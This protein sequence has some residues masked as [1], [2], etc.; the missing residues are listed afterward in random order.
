[1]S[2]FFSP[3]AVLTGQA[4]ELSQCPGNGP[5]STCQAVWKHK[6]CWTPALDFLRKQIPGQGPGAQ[7]C[8]LSK[9]LSNPHVSSFAT[10]TQ[11]NLTPSLPDPALYIRAVFVPSQVRFQSKE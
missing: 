3:S 6:R 7:W 11:G 5:A 9:A 4:D 8:F 10:L 2:A 1:M